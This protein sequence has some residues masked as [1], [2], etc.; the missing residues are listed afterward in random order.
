MLSLPVKAA[1][2]AARDPALVQKMVEA[3]GR[4]PAGSYQLLAAIARVASVIPSVVTMERL[5][6]GITTDSVEVKEQREFDVSFTDRIVK[7]PVATEL[8]IQLL[9]RVAPASPRL[10]APII[11][12]PVD[13]S[14]D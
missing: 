12:N 2:E 6:L 4:G 7:D 11:K 14:D 3:A 9:D 10:P 13:P 8:A 5:A 1:L